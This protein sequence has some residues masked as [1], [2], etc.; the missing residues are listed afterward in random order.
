MEDNVKKINLFVILAFKEQ[1]DK[2]LKKANC[3]KDQV[4]HQ[5]KEMDTTLTMHFTMLSYCFNIHNFFDH[6]DEIERFENPVIYHL[7]YG[8]DNLNTGV[9]SMLE[10]YKGKVPIV[11][12][13]YD[14]H[15]PIK[16]SKD[17]MLRY[18]DL[19][20]TYFSNHVNDESIKLC[21]MSYDNHLIY[22]YKEVPKS[23]K[24]ACMILRKETRKDYFKDSSK[25]KDVG[26]DLKKTYGLREGI[27]EFDQV[28]VF[29]RG[30][31]LERKNYKGGLSPHF[32]KYRALNNYKFNII[33]ENAIVDNFIS[34][35]ILDSFLSL[36]VPVYL[37]SPEIKKWIPESCFIDIRD[38]KSNAELISFLERMDDEAY[39]SYLSSIIRYRDELF[40]KFST[41]A[42][43]I[44][45]VYKWYMKNFK[46]DIE[47]DLSNVVECESHFKEASLSDYSFKV[48]LRKFYR[49]KSFNIKKKMA[50]VKC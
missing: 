32:E 4:G 14:P 10:K 15:S 43:F 5:K 12:R 13:S 17:Y 35:K 37:G 38:Y 16:T 18:H 46:G 30:W 40:D 20:L 36:T 50:L 1:T 42:N 28:D 23:R 19:I 26:L 45:P 24:L 8:R 2:Y 11:F 49:D 22:K 48:K 6:K 29:G 25:F 33:I 7:P 3:L 41:K 31:E 39:E 47:Y 34:E 21:H 44:D 9:E 27:V